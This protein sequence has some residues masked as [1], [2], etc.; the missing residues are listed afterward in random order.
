MKKTLIIFGILLFI[1]ACTVIFIGKSGRDTVIDTDTKID[2]I[3]VSKEINI[4]K[5]DTTKIAADT[6]KIKK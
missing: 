1:S 3:S 2:S 4:I 6:A 5:N